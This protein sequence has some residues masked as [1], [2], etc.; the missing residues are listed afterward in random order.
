LKWKKADPK[1]KVQYVTSKKAVIAKE[2]VKSTKT[3]DIDKKR[4]SGLGFTVYMTLEDA[5]VR[6]RQ[7]NINIKMKRQEEH[8][9]LI[10]V[11]YKGFKDKLNAYIPNAY[12][13]EFEKRYFD[14]SL[15]ELDEEIAES[16]M[17]RSRSVWIKAQTVIL[18]LRLE[19]FNFFNCSQ[20][21]Y[22]YFI[23]GEYSASYTSKVLSVMNKWGAFV[24]YKL[25]QPYLSIPTPVGRRLQQL[26]RAYYGDD[27]KKRKES[28]PLTPDLLD[29]GKEKM[30][31]ENY[32]ALF[33]AVWFG[34][35]PMEVR[36][37]LEHEDSYKVGLD[38]KGLCY[39][40]VYQTKL[41]SRHPNDRW[42]IIPLIFTEQ[43]EALKYI[44]EKK[45]KFPVNATIKRYF[46][47]CVTSYG[48]RKGFVDLMALKGQP[49]DYIS[50][51]MGHS[52]VD[53]TLR[54]Y[55][56]KEITQYIDESGERQ[57]IS[58]VDYKLGKGKEDS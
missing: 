34:L 47:P 53:R 42:K 40:M 8:K 32:K 48:P 45:F 1:W 7:L 3:W 16:S 29:S 33:I 25:G 15:F 38:D 43:L 57:S 22:D 2:N 4:W 41:M 52:S 13:E 27:K 54:N 37:L 46:G 58:T 21:I 50:Q 39:I 44:G 49:V 12:R 23:K 31:P 26:R 10:E 35:R 17:K 51:W 5:K 36:R 55:K 11:E 18:E 9:H 30:L 19:P 56:S 24:S 6:C 28:M 14:L 20:L